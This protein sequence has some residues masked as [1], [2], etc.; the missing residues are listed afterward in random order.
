MVAH[1]PEGGFAAARTDV[2]DLSMVV[3]P[4]LA[5]EMVCCSMACKPSQM[6]YTG[7]QCAAFGQVPGSCLTYMQ[8]IKDS[9]NGELSIDVQQ[10]VARFSARQSNL[11][12][13]N[14]HQ[15]SHLNSLSKTQMS[16]CL[17]HRITVLE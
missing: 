17:T 14:W 16:K 9:P 10:M 8:N 3:M 13:L 11:P 15:S 4:A 7:R 5:T 1:L 2:L 12:D 6:L